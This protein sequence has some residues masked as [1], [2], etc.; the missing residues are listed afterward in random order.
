MMRMSFLLM[1]VCRVQWW[2]FTQVGCQSVPRVLCSGVSSRQRAT[3]L[4]K[5][6]T[7]RWYCNVTHDGQQQRVCRHFHF[8]TAL[9]CLCR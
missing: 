1:Q 6:C 5:R 9:Y 8:Q 7:D 3:E 4:V 2:S